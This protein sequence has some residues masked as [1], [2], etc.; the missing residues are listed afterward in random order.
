MTSNDTR[1]PPM[2]TPKDVADRWKVTQ[3]TLAQWRW[4]GSGPSYLKL[5]G[6]VRYRLAD[7]EAYE[8]EN[9]SAASL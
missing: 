4:T 9:M 3:K 6:S 7:I 1:K 2:L 8:S 5:G